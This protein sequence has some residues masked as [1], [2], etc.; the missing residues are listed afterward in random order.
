MNLRPGLPAVLFLLLIRAWSSAQ[1]ARDTTVEVTASVQV[2][3][4]QIALTWLP[5]TFPTTLQKVFRKPKGA[6]AWTDLATLAN[7]ATAFTDPAV[8]LG[9]SYEYYVVRLFSSTDPGSASGYVNAGIRLPLPTVR[10]R[11]LLL[12]DDTMAAALAAELNGLVGD[13]VGDGWTVARQDV[14]R[15]GTVAATKAI[16][17]ALYNA[18]PT[19]TRSLILFGHVPVPYSGN[20][21]PD[22]HPDHRGAW[23]AD[24]Y[25]G[26]MNGVW[27]DTLVNNAS[28]SRTENRNIPGDGKFDQSGLPSDLE[29]EV[30]RIDLANL[31]SASPTPNETDLL[32]Q[33]LQ[34]DHAFRFKTGNYASIP[35]RGLIADNFG[36]FG[37]E[38][39]SASGW[40]NFTAFFGSAP[41]AIDQLGWFSTLENEAYLF[42]YGCGGGSY[43][44][45]GGIGVT[46]D[47]ATRKCLSVF[48]MVFGSYFGDW[49]VGDSFLRAPLAGRADSLGLVNVWAGRPHWHLY[50]MALGETVGYAARTTQ[51]NTGFG[52][53]GYVLNN[54]G[55]GVHIALM[56]DPTLRLHPVLP[57]ANLIIDSSSGNPSLSWTASGDTN[58]EGYT[59]LRSSSPTGP[60]ESVGGSFIA[61]TTF[62]DRSGTPG[63]S[64]HYQVRTVKLESSASGTYLNGSQGVFGT[65]NFASPVTREIQVTG[66]GHAIPN[67]DVTATVSAGTDFG[68][69]EATVQS[70][71]RT[72]T[73]AN[74]G[75]LALS[76][77][78]SPLVQLTGSV[79]FTVAPPAANTI[80]GAGFVTFQITFT[81]ATVGAHTT[82]VSIANNDPDEG[83][84]QFSI[85]G[86]GLPPAPEINVS[87]A[88]IAATLSPS[89]SATSLV[90]IGNTGAGLLHHTVTTSQSGYSF[91]DSNSFGGP[92]YAWIDI[93]ATGTEV[94]GFSN[95]DDAMSG[96][97]PIGFDF[98]FY[99]DSSNQHRF[100]SLYICTNAFI[101]FGNATPLFFGPSL[102]SLEASGNVVAAFWNDL[103]LDAS[104]HIYTQR[105]G[106]LF[107]IQFENITRYGTQNERVTC[108]I[109]LRQTGEIFIQYKQVPPGFTDYSVGI[110]DGQRSHGLQVA[111]HTNYAQPQ[112]AVRIVPPDYDLWLGSSIP[113]GTVASL[114]SQDF[115]ATLSSA[116]LSPGH[117][118][119][120]LQVDSDDADEARTLVPVELTVSGAEVEVLGNGLLIP[121]GDTTAMVV[122]GTDFGMAAIA[123]GSVA[124]TFTIRNSGSD[125]LTLGS[126]GVVGSGFSVTTQPSAS[127]PASGITTLVVTFAP[128]VAGAATGTV[129]FTTNDTNEGTYTFTT[130]GLALS[131]IESWRLTHFGSIANTGNAA[132]LMDPDGDGLRNLAEYGFSLDPNTAS[133]GGAT[134]QVNA[135]GYLE[136]QFTRN[137]GRTDLTYTVEASSNLVTWTPIASSSAGGATVGSG[138]HSVVETGA[139]AVRTVRV[140]DA[141]TAA[142]GSPRFLRVKIVRN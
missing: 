30:G 58:V 86:T 100:S 25:Y 114:G 42:A 71:T 72:F 84:Y 115:N 59:V 65:G 118:F 52:A 87:P 48:N 17:Q 97:I 90:S 125:P 62:V 26:D 41:G 138:A 124:R 60:F 131:P 77:T 126:V 141:Q 133:S 120:S 93:S 123:G 111:Y 112:L 35:R 109:I 15:N 101:S 140:E 132:D 78:G 137:T 32:R 29:L 117:Y 134:V 7:N 3:P 103:I 102:P 70:V 96:A 21:N 80:P 69:A 22:G 28:A 27:T 19:H 64:Y 53:G 122:D 51:N 11:V 81:P 121:S 110:Q 44:G 74:D 39:F 108:E 82:I 99:D 12:V 88:S 67:G 83:A 6:A 40:R 13:L 55:Y 142:A 79:A 129:T 33:Y 95:P 37:G 47:Y 135:G 24:G 73:I 136:I 61:G 85:S 68:S 98:P 57:P 116:G 105:I 56:G 8:A 45:A 127:V 46:G 9:V 2:S 16:I 75:T 10:G 20:L 18:D 66:N 1:T 107:V 63:Q 94:T 49:D 54:A 14:P 130:T 4:P 139:G 76:L 50:H 31:P 89:G 119:A 113:N 104:G 23:P 5:T 36:Y 106:D 38:A 34:R 128:T 91:R 92:G 43:G